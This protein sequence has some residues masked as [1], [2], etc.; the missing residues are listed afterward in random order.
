[1]VI[2]GALRGLLAVSLCA[3]LAGCSENFGP[4]PPDGGSLVAV[5]AEAATGP[6]RLRAVLSVA[7]SGGQVWAGSDGGLF[8]APLVAG[9][10]AWL[11]DHAGYLRVDG[12]ERTARIDAVASDPAG[13]LLLHLARVTPILA[14]VASTDGGNTR[15]ALELPDPVLQQVDEIGVF[16]PS[17]TWPFGAWVVR[18]G[19]SITVRATDASE[20]QTVQLPGSPRAVRG[21]R[22]RTDGRLV[23][24][25]NTASGDAVWAT[26][27][28][29]PLR[30]VEVASDPRELLDAAPE[31]MGWLLAHADGVDR[32]A[33]AWLRW[34]GF[35]VEA[36]RFDP[37]PGTPRWVALGRASDGE[38]RLALGA[39]AGSDIATSV[40]VEGE[41]V[42]STLLRRGSWAAFVTRSAGEDRIALARE[43]AASLQLRAARFTEVDL[44]A[45]TSLD[46]SAG[47]VAVG[48]EFGGEVFAGPA[49][50]PASF[51]QLG[52][53]PLSSQ[54][55][56]LAT[57]VEGRVLAGSFGVH[58]YDPGLSR[59]ETVNQGQF[60]YQP[61]DFGGP[62]V[63]GTLARD[64][65]GALW[66]GAV[67]G[68]GVYRGT[69]DPVLGLVWER[70]HEGFGAPGSHQ[71]EFGLPRVTQARAFAFDRDGTTWMGGFRGG[72][73]RLDP[74]T[75]VWSG[76]N[77]GLPLVS[78][79]VNDSCCA[80][81]GEREIDVRDLVVLD[82]TTLMAATAWGV[83]TR[84]VGD[85]RWQ[86][87]SLGLA[88]R[89]VFALAVHPRRPGTVA[90]GTST[91]EGRSQW[92]FLTEDAGRTWF[93]VD[94]SVLARDCIDLVW[95]RP[96]RNE[97]VALLRAQGAL[98]VELAP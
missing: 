60:T 17:P 35:T 73:W 90:A 49:T 34:N 81:P 18:Q 66:L 5:S 86:E 72:V 6:Q 93:P 84:E 45:I 39:G 53:G 32:D 88:N 95:S 12:F 85:A 9:S 61:G 96:D 20:W 64:E 69:E 10:S 22:A 19:V 26:S 48:S 28:A 54:V 79:A 52:V 27:L 82:G 57:D 23:L 58:R 13:R 70:L 33:S 91:A 59:W 24:L 38:R 11:V 30:A 80:V 8:R 75:E 25:V 51:V 77:E 46:R 71:T 21:L 62:V 29:D 2:S 67:N 97:L 78:G 55:A 83:F 50:D 1:M 40:A 47:T 36:L 16:A 76:A 98:R 7:L 4:P 92:L 3:G 94:V 63:V 89:D 74:S 14:L 15:V 44:R 43:G 42:H 65:V 87:R 37:G 41:P 56:T 68:D 31:G